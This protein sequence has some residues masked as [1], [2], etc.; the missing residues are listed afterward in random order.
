MQ[1]RE[2]MQGALSRTGQGGMS[3]PA[4]YI[5]RYNPMHE[6]QEQMRRM[7]ALL[8]RVF[9][10]SPMF[11]APSLDV[12]RNETAAAEPDVDLSESDAE[13]VLQAA[14]PGLDP[15]DI[16]IEATEDTIVVT[17]ERRSNASH[18]GGSAQENRSSGADGATAGTPPGAGSTA[19]YEQPSAPANSMH[20]NRPHTQHRMSRFNSQLRYRLAYTLPTAIQ[21]DMA[22]AEFRNGVL[23][24]HLPKQQQSAVR[25][26]QIPVAAA[27]ANPQGSGASSMQSGLQTPTGGMVGVREG[28]P[29]SKMGANYAPTA[30]ESHAAQTQSTGERTGYSEHLS[31]ENETPVSA[32]QTNPVGSPPVAPSSTQQNSI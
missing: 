13:Y 2:R 21:P 22:R 4:G 20:A 24:I 29:G 9:G 30:G 8:N 32:G 3:R 23:E 27:A 14:L 17:A 11:A 12:W 1:D 19:Q 31:R 26:I 16:R 10:L 28:N 7:D 25:T 15:Q 5:S 6:M 18:D